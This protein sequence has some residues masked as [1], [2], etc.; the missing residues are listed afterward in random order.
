M[1]DGCSSS[2]APR[3]DGASEDHV[4][5]RPAMGNRQELVSTTSRVCCTTGRDQGDGG[6]APDGR[7][8]DSTE[9]LSESRSRSN[10]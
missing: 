7:D 8:A 4:L 5:W 1:G 9:R 2:S 6:G 10:D 3:P